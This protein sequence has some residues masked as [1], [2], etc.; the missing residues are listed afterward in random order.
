MWLLASSCAQETSKDF[1]YVVIRLE[2]HQVGHD[3]REQHA[4]DD[5]GEE[6]DHDARVGRLL[7]SDV[8]G[9]DL[10]AQPALA[11]R[12][13]DPRD[14]DREERGEDDREFLPEGH[15]STLGRKITADTGS[16][17]TSAS[18]RSSPA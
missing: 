12:E 10:L 8:R 9:R 2:E 17:D 3:D 13:P 18:P 15:R 1:S 5:R 7:G 4:A 16:P 11:K 14:Q 6:R